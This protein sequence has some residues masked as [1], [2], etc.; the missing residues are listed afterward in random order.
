MLEWVLIP[1]LTVLLAIVGYFLREIHSDFQIWKR[2][3]MELKSVTRAL[4]VE[5]RALKRALYHPYASL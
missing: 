3:I 2:D 1:V 5:V 4:E